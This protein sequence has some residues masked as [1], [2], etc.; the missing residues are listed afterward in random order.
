M[1]RVYIGT[2]VVS[3]FTFWYSVGVGVIYTVLF[4]F[5]L[6]YLT[7]QRVIK[8]VNLVWSLCGHHDCQHSSPVEKK[9][10]ERV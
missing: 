6:F 9:H 10:V 8:Y 1:W 7:I 2:T 3:D 4:Y 5:G